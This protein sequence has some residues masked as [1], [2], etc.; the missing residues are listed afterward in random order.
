[1]CKKFLAS[2]ILFIFFSGFAFGN[3]STSLYTIKAKSLT[4]FEHEQIHLFVQSVLAQLPPALKE[5]LPTPVKI[6]F[7]KLSKSTELQ[8]PSCPN[9]E[10]VLGD[11][12]NHQ[13][14]K[15]IYARL[16][17]E[18]S[19]SKKVI[20]LNRLFI[21]II[22]E[23]EESA[24]TYSCGHKNLYKLAEATLIHELTHLYDYAKVIAATDTE[25]DYNMQDFCASVD[26]DE[27][28]SSSFYHQCIPFLKD[29]SLS[30]TW[31]YRHLVG[32]GKGS[33]SS[34]KLTLRSPDPYE[35]YNLQEHLAVNMEYFLL[36]PEYQ[37]RRPA[38]YQL[39]STHFDFSPF[40]EQVNCK[41][42][43]QIA[44]SFTNIPVDIDPDRIYEIHYLLAD[45]GEDISSRFGHSM[46]R[47]ILCHPKREK[48]GPECYKDVSHHVVFSFRAEISEATINNFSGFT[49]KYPSQLFIFNMPEI[50][51]EYTIFEDRD[52]RS[53][54]LNFSRDQ[55]K[56]FVHQ[57]L[58][59]YWQYQ[60]RY[61]FMTN[62][63]ASE[64]LHFL[65]GVL[66]SY[67]LQKYEPFVITPKYIYELLVD[68]GWANE[69]AFDD[70]KAVGR[71]LFKSLY[72]RMMEEFNKL[73][74]FAGFPADLD[75]EKY[76]Q[77]TTA[78]E[79]RELFKTMKEQNSGNTKA[80]AL[81]FMMLEYGVKS[82]VEQLWKE[83]M[84]EL[85]ADP[86]DE[87][88]SEQVFGNIKKAKELTFEVSP[89]NLAES[90]YGIPQKDEIMK[91]E[92]LFWIGKEVVKLYEEI[93]SLIQQDKDNFPFEQESAVKKNLQF[94]LL[95][96]RR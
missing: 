16:S 7:K 21:P 4:P 71:Y 42:N 73:T 58:E 81:S 59:F 69:S 19:S 75:I 2:W 49:G 84:Q 45:S 67:Q 62:N 32:W 3:Q 47:L 56:Q 15:E 55:I 66:P 74:A 26:Q 95:A 83:A 96:M 24:P 22:I 10:G 6:K 93:I 79:R 8:S 43:T 89:F 44:Y 40:A 5:N 91:R 94:F 78:E 57:G 28:D 88:M 36:D 53:L 34:N 31:R 9:E 29:H 68:N 35:S 25:V 77:E 63:C 87:K 50:I 27:H 37:C 12:A 86:E 17:W 90:G 48:V 13:S 46:F 23:G 70:P 60:G 11:E 39:L 64:S 76:I 54:P 52:L 41:V 38:T 80:L 14:F 72:S 30:S 61:Y 92:D 85:L 20:E 33:D 1:M 82:Y 18:W 65:A 51:S